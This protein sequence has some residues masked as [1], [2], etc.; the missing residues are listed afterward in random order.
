MIYCRVIGT[1]YR[2]ETVADEHRLTR[3]ALV[4]V[5]PDASSAIESQAT[6]GERTDL[7]P[8]SGADVGG[9]VVPAPA[10]IPVRF[11]DELHGVV[12]GPDRSSLIWSQQFDFRAVPAVSANRWTQHSC[13]QA[14]DPI[15]TDKG[16]GTLDIIGGRHA[17]VVGEDRSQRRPLLGVKEAK[18]PR[19]EDL[20]GLDV[21]EGRFHHWARSSGTGELLTKRRVKIGRRSQDATEIS[22]MVTNVQMRAIH[23]LARIS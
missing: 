6:Q 3:P 18:V 11:L 22:M 9:V 20:D 7:P 10:E 8:F 17:H 4:G 19:H 13:H 14:D 5:A 2:K 21:S 1:A 23:S 16:L 12:H 15:S